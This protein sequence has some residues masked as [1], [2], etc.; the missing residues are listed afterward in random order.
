MKKIRATIRIYEIDG[1]ELSI[2][3]DKFAHLESHDNYSNMVT[4][5]IDGKSFGLN[6]DD[7]S[8]S[9]QRVKGFK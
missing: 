4:L 8:D 6:A 1:E 3:S 7:L 5:F 2:G 9:I